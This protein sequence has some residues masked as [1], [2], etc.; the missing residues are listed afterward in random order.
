MSEVKEVSNVSA[1]KCPGR[2][3]NGMIYK[4]VNEVD[5]EIYIGATCMSLPKRKFEHK[6]KSKG[7]LMKKVYD[8]LNLIGWEFV[9]II[10]IEKFPCADK[11]ELESRCR[12][13][14]DE[15]K[16]SLNMKMACCVR[17]EH[18]REMNKCIECEGKSI[19]EHK[20]ERT[21]CKDCQ[22][23]SICPH[24]RDYSKCRDCGGSSS[25]EHSSKKS[26][27]GKCNPSVEEKIY[28]GCGGIFKK[29][30]KWVHLKTN[31]HTRWLER[32]E[33]DR[34]EAE[35]EEAEQYEE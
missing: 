30:C 24:G 22:G 2:Y 35:Q 28:C 19:C 25:C 8:H 33:V 26:Q 16:P 7:K 34:L 11:M 10:L 20:R 31:K 3:Q 21:K 27:C 6:S 15:M 14:I 12:Y 13:W 4:L 9:K 1:S 5:G 17:C 29:K 32:V 18:D 23:G